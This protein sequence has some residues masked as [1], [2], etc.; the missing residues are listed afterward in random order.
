MYKRG[1]SVQNIMF[2]FVHVAT[3]AIPTTVHIYAQI[4][5]T[6]QNI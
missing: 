3:I 6:E 2:Y 1:Q 4:K 5:W